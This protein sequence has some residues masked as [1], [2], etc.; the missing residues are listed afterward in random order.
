METLWD[1]HAAQNA[2]LSGEWTE[3]VK[4]W[5]GAIGVGCRGRLIVLP[6]LATASQIV[7]RLSEVSVQMLVTPVLVSN[8]TGWT[9]V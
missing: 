7:V 2:Q 9:L 3:V 5:V 4:R 8:T 1:G 6:K